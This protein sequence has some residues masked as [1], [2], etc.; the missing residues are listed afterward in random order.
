MPKDFRATTLERA[1]GRQLA[2]W[3]NERELSLTE[4][5]QRV[6]F[7]SAKLSMMENAVQPSAPVD[8]MALGYVYKVPT[9]EWQ[10]VVLRAQ[11]AERVRTSALNN[12]LNFDSAAD[13]ANLVFEASRLRAFTTDLIPAVL[14]TPRYTNAVMQNDDPVRTA[15]LATVR[16][17]WATRLNG[18]DP[19]VVQ[20]VF[21]ESVLRQVIGGPR[22]MKA[23]LLHLM[24]ISEHPTVSVQVV[25]Y[26]AGAYPAMGSPFT[27]LDFPH[28]QHND[29][30]YLETFIKGE[31]V[32]DP[33]LTEQC[34][35]RF[36]SL[37]QL[38]LDPGESLELIAEAAAESSCTGI[39]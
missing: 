35:Q 19:L 10:A 18:K 7:S 26:G 33:V 1:V 30:A 24:E 21:P 20:A 32:E 37:Q 39:R 14:Q 5:G 15:R 34:A 8:V 23:Q 28:R 27:L 13:F 29:V 17:A 25:P 31:Y 3:R 36:M 2:G 16:E 22:A 12:A 11:H 4:A 9:P 38:A 6:G